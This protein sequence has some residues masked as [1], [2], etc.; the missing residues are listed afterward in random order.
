M[1][2]RNLGRT[3]VKVSPLCLGTM[4]FGGQTNESESIQIIHD[5]LDSGINF[6]DTANMYNL[7]R[8]EEV[9]GKALVGR[10]DS[11]VL[12]TKGRSKMG[13]APNQSGASRL[14]LMHELNASLKRL[15]TDHID[16]YYCHAPDP[17]TRLEET[18][19]ALDD[20]VSSGKVLYTA[21]SNFRAYQLARVLGI[22]ERFGLRNL[23]CIQPLYNMFNRDIE[24]ELLPLCHE[25]G[26]GVVSYS[27]LARGILSGKYRPG[28][29]PPEGSRAHRQDK[30]MLQAEWREASLLAAQNVA[31]YC[32]FRNINPSQFALSWCLENQAI[33]S[34]IIGPRTFDQWRDNFSSLQYRLT[35]EDEAFVNSIVPPGEHTGIGFQDDA[36]PIQGR[37][38]N[39]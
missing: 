11:V 7:G 31:D 39:P 9:I 12:A 21:V 5:A 16:I 15:N 38:V 19:R 6:L 26:L 32:R 10:R 34:V 17:A 29:A 1:Q 24:V 3:G 35:P 33:S 27:P 36:Y 4:M 23:A 22:Q 30:R 8:S 13:D 18:V 14:H 25:V 37:Y 28:E 20:M 2:Y